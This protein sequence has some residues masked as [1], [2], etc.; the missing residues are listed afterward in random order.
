MSAKIG[1]ARADGLALDKQ[2][3]DTLMEGLERMTRLAGVI[4]DRFEALEQRVGAI[5]AAAKARA[6]GEEN[7][8]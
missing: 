8:A 4:A 5:E 6:P 3:H 2:T 7:A 1:A